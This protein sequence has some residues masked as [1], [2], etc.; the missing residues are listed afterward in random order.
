MTTLYGDDL[1]KTKSVRTLY[2]SNHGI[3]HAHA[4]TTGTIKSRANTVTGYIHMRVR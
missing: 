3:L 1:H 4:D 2:L